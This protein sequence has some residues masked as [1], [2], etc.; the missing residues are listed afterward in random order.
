VRPEDSGVFDPAK[1]KP[2]QPKTAAEKQALLDMDD[3]AEIQPEVEHTAAARRAMRRTKHQ[4]KTEN[5]D[6]D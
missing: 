4:P 5:T 6:K 2:A 3:P 1:A